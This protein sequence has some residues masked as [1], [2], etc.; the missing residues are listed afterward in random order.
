MT[1]VTCHRCGKHKPALAEAPL[2]GRWGAAVVEQTC[3]DCWQAWSEEQVRIINH[4]GLHTYR[5]A[6]KQVL[7]GRMREF[8]Q[9]V[10]VGDPTT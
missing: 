1:E 7:Y 10:G 5:P 3:A 6:D 8:L 9:I 2:P 4:L